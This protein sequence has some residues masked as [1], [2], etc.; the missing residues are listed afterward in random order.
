M[1]MRLKCHRRLELGGRRGL[2][3]QIDVVDS[4]GSHV[5]A[6]DL[7]CAAIDSDIQNAAGSGAAT[8]EAIVRVESSES[9]VEEL[10]GNAWYTHISRERVWFEGQYSQGDGGEVSLAQFKLAVQTY[11]GFLADPERKP[12]VVEFP[13]H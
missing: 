6:Y 11:V 1:N 3:R 8:V 4:G 5:E 2:S 13:G 7:M 10:G 9:L 12:L